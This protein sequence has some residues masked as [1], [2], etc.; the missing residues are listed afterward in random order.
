MLIFEAV[1]EILLNCVK[2]A[3]G[4][5][6]RGSIAAVDQGWRVERAR[7]RRGVWVRPRRDEI[8]GKRRRFRAIQHSRAD[9]PAGG[10]FQDR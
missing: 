1:R 5:A 7:E 2:H 8:G 4:L 6:G 9:H 10:R 3:G